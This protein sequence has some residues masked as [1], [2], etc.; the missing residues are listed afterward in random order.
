M[1]CKKEECSQNVPFCHLF[2]RET[3]RVPEEML[4]FP[5]FFPANIKHRLHIIDNDTGKELNPVLNKPLVSQTFKPNKVGSYVKVS[6]AVCS[7]VLIKP[8]VANS[9]N[10][11]DYVVTLCMNNIFLVFS[12]MWNANILNIFFPTAQVNHLFLVP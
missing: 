8:N 5:K 3:F 9:P 11:L 7:L 4:L 1:T 10:C 12:N 6:P 2:V